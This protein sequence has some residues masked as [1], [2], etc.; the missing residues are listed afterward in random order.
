M[1]KLCYNITTMRVLLLPA[2]VCWVMVWSC[3]CKLQTMMEQFSW[4]Q[5]L[6]AERWRQALLTV[7]ARS[8]QQ[9]GDLEAKISQRINEVVP[10]QLEKILLAEMNNIVLPR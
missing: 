4:T 7:E 9:M 2:P 3:L 5:L 10:T 1:W 8:H 6:K